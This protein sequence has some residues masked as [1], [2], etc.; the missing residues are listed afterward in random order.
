MAQYWLS[1]RWPNDPWTTFEQLRRGLDDLFERQP[2]RRADAYPPVNLYETSDGYVLTAELP[3]LRSDEIEITLERNRVTLRGERR[4]EH[5][6]DASLHRVERQAGLFRRTI[7]LPAN[8]DAEK[9]EATYRLGVLVLR[10]P[11]APEHQPRR[12]SVGSA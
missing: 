4:I 11:K 6:Q 9:A 12:I 8:G 10:I 1:N 5:P 2:T 7:E 3:G